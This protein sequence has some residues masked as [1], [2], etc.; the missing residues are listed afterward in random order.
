[1]SIRVRA[2]GTILCVCGLVALLAECGG[3]ETIMS[4]PGR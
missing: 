3:D 2:I 1:M 4:I